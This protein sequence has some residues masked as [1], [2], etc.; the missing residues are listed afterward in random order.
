MDKKKVIKSPWTIGLS[1]AFFSFLLTVLYDNLKEKPILSTVVNIIK[2]I[3]DFVWSILNNDLK[4][5]WILI[6]FVLI[7]L[8]KVLIK[9]IFNSNSVEDA[10]PDFLNYKEGKLKKWKWSWDWK[11]NDLE[12]TWHVL[13]LSAHCPKCDTPMTDLSTFY[14]LGFNCPRCRYRA[15]DMLCEDPED[16]ERLIIDNLDRVKK[17]TLQKPY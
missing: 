17:G 9:N 5:W 10:K 2:S 4:L 3:K 6:A 14:G 12:S 15:Q 8:I 11:W 16:I 1:V 7:I 13:N